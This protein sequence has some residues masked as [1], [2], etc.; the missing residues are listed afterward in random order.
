MHFSVVATAV[1]AAVV[2][3]LTVNPAAA[4]AYPQRPVRMIIANGAGTAPD[5]IGRLLANKLAE[6]WG[7]A[8]IV[9]NRPGATG[10]IA[11]ELTARAA[12]DG[13]TLL[14]STMTNL[15][16]MLM[17]QK[18]MLATELGAV[19]LVGTTPFAIVV[20]P[21]TP[22]KSVGELI[23]YAKARQGQLR[24]G[25][26][27]A[28]GSTHLCMENFNALNGLK[29][30]HVPYANAANTMTDLMSGGIH[31][32]CPAVPS[33][34]AFMASGKIRVLGV[35]YREPTK[36]LP[37]VP[38]VADAVPGFE[39][40]GWYGMNV[41]LK[42]PPELIKRINADLVKALKDPQLQERMLAVGAEPVGSTPAEFTAF[43]NKNTE[44]WTKVLKESGAKLGQ[45]F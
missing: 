15:I 27:G 9:D 35:T 26:A 5:V 39:L 18:Y 16:V 32:Y 7:Q 30:T 19:T 24:Y 17:H 1:A 41:P 25:S 23:A 42:T 10:L 28:W 31:I 40:Y 33:L 45:G 12:P 38:P 36:L 14:L 44:Q 37:G 34:P 8:I 13:Y 11:T 2:S 3:T 6:S 21:T 20:G 4:Q 29:M 43:L 22:V